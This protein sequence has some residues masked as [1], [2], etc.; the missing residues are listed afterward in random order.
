[1][2]ERLGWFI[3]NG[4]GDPDDG[5]NHVIIGR[6][7]DGGKAWELTDIGIG[8]S[9]EIFFADESHG[10]A[11]NFKGFDGQLYFTVDGGK[12]W[13]L[14][15]VFPSEHLFS[16]YFANPNVGW[17]ATAHDLFFSGG[18]LRTQD[19][20]K[21]WQYKMVFR[22]AIASAFFLGEQHAWVTLFSQFDLM[23]THDGG[24]TWWLIPK[25]GMHQ[26]WFISPSDGWG[27]KQKVNEDLL[28]HT[29]DGD[30][31]WQLLPLVPNLSLGRIY[32]IDERTGW[33]IITTEQ[34]PAGIPTRTALLHTADGGQT[35][36]VQ[37]S[38]DTRLLD[39]QFINHQGWLAVTR[40]FQLVLF[41]TEDGG[42]TWEEIVPEVVAGVHFNPKQK[43][44][45]TWGKLKQQR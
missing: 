27:I 33:M 5:A 36:Q 22:D 24:E 9:G 44:T 37:F 18:I 45:T 12:T 2:N 30:K 15:T 1:V 29:T 14:E 40:K 7:N 26:M 16:L 8:S 28:Y 38:W 31:T 21:T 39:A 42:E 32:F 11:T 25:A 13:E 4:I 43:L 34:S 10:W 20:G 17:L 19:G 23:V 41:G 6:T 35:W 3:G